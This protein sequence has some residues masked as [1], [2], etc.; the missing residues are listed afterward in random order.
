MQGSID[1]NSKED[2]SMDFQAI[3]QKAESYRADMARFLRDM[4]RIPSESWDGVF[5]GSR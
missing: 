4:I 2:G 3:R 1:V 5:S